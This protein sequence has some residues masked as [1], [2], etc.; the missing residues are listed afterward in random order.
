MGNKLVMGFHT[1]IDYELVCDAAAVENAIR[2]FQIRDEELGVPSVEVDCERS[3]WVSCLS[4]LKSGTGGEILPSDPQLCSRFA[5]RF[6]F[7]TTIGGTSA[8]AALA[9]AKIG[10]PSTMS[11]SRYYPV[12][13]DLIPDEI[14]C[15]YCGREEHPVIYP[16]TNLQYYSGMR[17]HAGDIDFTT[18]RESRILV[19]R[20]PDS[21]TMDVSEAFI[22]FTKD[23][24]V[25]LIASFTTVTDPQILEERIASVTRILQQLPQDC[26]I[27]CEE[28]G[29]IRD[30]F[31]RSMHKA[32]R[33]LA[34]IISMNED[35]LQNYIGRKI[36]LMEPTIV[37]NALSEAHTGIGI[38]TM[39]VHTSK[40]AVAYGKRARQCSKALKG[41]VNMGAVR[42][43]YGDAYGKE[44]YNKTMETAVYAPEVL[45]FCRELELLCPEKI[46]CI[47]CLDLSFVANPTTLGLG[48][49][50]VGGL[51]PGLLPD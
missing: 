20:D 45:S 16:H 1:C 44:E 47:P 49:S 31:R 11:S 26:I 32:L 40:W 3:L 34:E 37:K 30:S 9:L 28:G 17:I 46:C 43:R 24:K 50:F 8:R 7:Q 14:T 5:A 41:A 22:P 27:V 10:I 18:T 2:E 42:F 33:G 51:L 48:D 38:D 4:Y 36:D 15:F 13:D 6:P 12:L 39:I 19:S 23:A 35:E 21:M 29:Y 25:F